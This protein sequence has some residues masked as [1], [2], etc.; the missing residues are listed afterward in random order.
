MRRRCGIKNFFYPILAASVFVTVFSC[1]F[2]PVMA[3]G[4]QPLT[5]LLLEDL[6]FQNINKSGELTLLY[7]LLFL[8]VLVSGCGIT[9]FPA[10]IRGVAMLHRRLKK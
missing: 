5:D 9:A 3:A 10:L 1:I 8:S 4:P 2:L 7:V 6:S